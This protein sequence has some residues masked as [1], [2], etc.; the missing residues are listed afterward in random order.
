M[1]AARFFSWRMTEIELLPFGGVAKT[2]EWG[3]VPSKEELIVAVAG[4]AYNG[5]MIVFAA[6]CYVCG[7]WSYAWAD[8]FVTANL[9]LAGFNLLPVYPLDGG[10]ILQAWMN[11]KFPYRQAVMYTLLVSW[12]LTVVLFVGSL[13]PLW[14]GQPLLLNV[15]VIAVFLLISNVLLWRQRN[16]QYMRFLLSRQ[17]EK[18]LKNKPVSALMVTEE[19][20]IISVTKKW[21]KEAYNI[22]VVSDTRGNVVR[23]LPEESV[24]WHFFNGTTPYGK[25]CEFLDGPN[26]A[27]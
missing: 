7:W 4:P 17:T 23:V 18:N 14:F 24:I 19:D 6:F 26:R 10:R 22:V 16:Y 12:T 13:I 3:T 20:T 5:I 8:F 2:D 11:Y 21:K 25:F 9:W 27:I 1:T 15:G